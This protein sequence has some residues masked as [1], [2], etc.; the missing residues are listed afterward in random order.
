[1]KKALMMFVTA[2]LFL[3][4]SVAAVLF[5]FQETFLFFPEKL[6][7]NYQFD[8]EGKF[9]EVHVKMEDGNLIHGLLF[10][11]EQSKGLI[12]YLH[13]NAGSLRSWGGVAEVYTGLDYDVFVVDYRGYGKSEGRISGEGQLVEDMQTVYRELK[14]RYSE[15][16]IVVLGYS[17]GSGPAAQLAAANHPG[18]LVLQAPF[19]SLKDLIRQYIPYLPSFLIKYNFRN[20]AYIEQCKMPVV[21]IHGDRDQVIHHRSSIRLKE[22]LKEDDTLIILKGQEH[23]GMTFSREYRDV[24]EEILD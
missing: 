15:D 1:M 17:I 23:N 24:I 6:D 22:H 3:V 4:L 18:M 8:F 5:F 14:K 10:K 7:R 19:F 12:F 11:A 9:E 16:K 2:F 13:G 21:L 20:Y